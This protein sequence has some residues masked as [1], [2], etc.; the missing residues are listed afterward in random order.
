[1]QLKDICS[2]IPSMNTYLPTRI[3]MR[4]SSLTQID[5]KYL[6]TIKS[7]ISGLRSLKCKRDINRSNTIYDESKKKKYEQIMWEQKKRERERERV[8]YSS[9]LNSNN[10]KKRVIERE[11]NKTILTV[12]AFIFN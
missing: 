4:N 9:Y 7:I 11:K 5:W 12:N 10:V 8:K 3:D 6:Q 2:K 1:M